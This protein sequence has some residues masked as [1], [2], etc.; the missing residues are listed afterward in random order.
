MRDAV[1]VKEIN[2]PTG[3][4]ERGVV[5]TQPFLPKQFAGR[6]FK[7]VRNARIGNDQEIIA[8]N[9]KYSPAMIG[10]GT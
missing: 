2:K 5:L 7:T 9:G 8:R 3:R 1:V 6:R 10:D 4:H